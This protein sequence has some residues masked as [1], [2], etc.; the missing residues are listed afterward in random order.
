[1][2]VFNLV[3]IERMKEFRIAV[4]FAWPSFTRLCGLHLDRRVPS[5]PAVVASPP[6]GLAGLA[7]AI[8]ALSFSGCGGSETT[9]AKPALAQTYFFQN[10]AS[11]SNALIES[12]T[13]GASPFIARLLVQVDDPLL[14]TAIEVKIQPKPGSVS[15]A[16]DIRYS[17]AALSDR[18]YLAVSTNTVNVPVFGLYS[19]YTN[20]VLVNLFF[21]DGTTRTLT[22]NVTAPPYYDPTG[23]YQHLTIVKQRSAGSSLGY[24]F[25]FMKSSVGSPVIVDTDGEIRWVAPGVSNSTSSAFHDNQ[26]VIGEATAPIVQQLRLDGT[27]SETALALAVATMFTH[28][29][30]FGKTGLLTDVTLETDGVQNIMSNVLEIEDTGAV[31][32]RWDVGAILTAYMTSR[33]DDASAF[34]RPGVDWF[35]NNASIYDSSDDS[36]I[37]SSRENFVIKLDYQTGRIIWILGDPTKYWYSFPSLRAK[38]LLLSPGGLY[39]IGQHA[40][41]ITSKGHLMLF[42][43][44]FGSLNQPAGDPAGESRTYSAVSAYSIDTATMTAQNVWNFNAGKTIYSDLCSSAYEAPDTSLL[45]DYSTADGGAEAMLMGLDLNH[46]VVFEFQY[47]SHNC[48]AGWN[49]VP[50]ALDSLTVD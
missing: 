25:I 1:V 16:V 35:H 26:F 29:I 21:E 30:D 37:V 38:A 28:N 34:V 3:W 40:I 33:G 17:N 36:I 41:S 48:D 13:P 4:A 9:A 43:D 5:K 10:D 2:I 39:P 31:L 45:V 15:K 27:L 8:A 32:N 24:D 7:I 12:D 18:G 11:R 6:V 42:N 14:L 46:Q 44:G 20:Q 19:G 49:A 47:P 50:F 23:I 22:R